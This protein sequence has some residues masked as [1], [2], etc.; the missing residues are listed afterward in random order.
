MSPG[1]GMAAGEEFDEGDQ[2]DADGDFDGDFDNTETRYG[3]N[4]Q[5]AAGAPMGAAKADVVDEVDL[6]S[7]ASVNR[8]ILQALNDNNRLL[9]HLVATQAA[10]SDAHQRSLKAIASGSNVVEKEIHFYFQGKLADL[11]ADPSKARL[12]IA[13]GSLEHTRGTI[14][15]MVVKS[16][17]STFP[18]GFMMQNDKINNLTKMPVVSQSGVAGVLYIPAKCKSIATKEIISSNESKATRLF[19][20]AFP[21]YTV[22][23]LQNELIR[24]P[25]KDGKVTFLAPEKHPVTECILSRYE[26]KGINIDDFWS[27][28]SSKY[29]FDESEVTMAVN[30]ISKKLISEK[31]DMSLDEISFP[32]V[33]ANLSDEVKNN[34]S[35]L[36]PALRFKDTMEIAGVIK[37]G[38]AEQELNKI[39]VIELE[40]LLSYAPAP[41]SER[42]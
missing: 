37:S 23:N 14:L 8:A 39:G 29:V 24:N 9:S 1:S 4:E 33:R 21:S 6:S 13:K 38:H 27:E 30:E 36:A 2:F 35:S 40:C 28:L 15:S 26:A 19:A 31:T 17:S 11:A 12:T 25:K 20:E 5:L 42:Q 32:L 34:K 22:D 16:G 3:G 18:A 7:M 10:N 41:G